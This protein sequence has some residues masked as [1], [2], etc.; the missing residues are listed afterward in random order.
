MARA[1]K[2]G[3]LAITFRAVQIVALY[4]DCAPGMAALERIALR[5]ICALEPLRALALLE[6]GLFLG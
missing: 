5:D 1:R 4:E 6:M 2:P 3:Y